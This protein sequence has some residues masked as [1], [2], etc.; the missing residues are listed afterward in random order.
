[1]TATEVFK[2]FIREGVTAPERLALTREIKRCFRDE[3][4]FFYK[5]C[6]GYEIPSREVV[7]KTFVERI[8]EVSS[9]YN[10]PFGGCGCA[11]RC[12]TLTSFMKYFLYYL[13]RIVGNAKNKNKY[14]KMSNIE[15]IESQGYKRFWQLRLIK[16]WHEFLKANIANAE[17]VFGYG[18]TPNY[19]LKTKTVA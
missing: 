4:S 10:N 8:I 7:E 16:K 6:W 14:L 9:Y 18:T 13:P 2:M 12:S 11:S 19:R 3:N 1:M 17:Y 15:V 5:R